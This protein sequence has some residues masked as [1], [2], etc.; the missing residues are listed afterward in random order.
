M[1]LSLAPRVGDVV[2]GYRLLRGLGSR[3][4]HRFVAANTN[5]RRTTPRVIVDLLEESEGRVRTAR[6]LA[7][8]RHPK[9]VPVR[10]VVVEGRV[11]AVESDFVGGEWFADLL[12][13]SGSKATPLGAMLRVLLDVLEGLSALH[14]LG[15]P[16]RQPLHFM[17]G[18]LAPP[19]ILIGADGVARIAHSVRAAA[20]DPS[21]PEVIGYLAPEVLLQDQTTDQRADVY[22]AGVLLWEA[23]T[24]RRLHSAMDAGE[25]VVSLLGGRVALAEVPR[26]APWAQPLAEVAKRALSPELAARHTTAAEMAA[27]VRSIAGENLGSRQDVAG[28]VEALAGARIRAR[29]SGGP[30]WSAKA[31]ARPAPLVR[32]AVPPPAPPRSLPERL[33]VPTPIIP[34]AA[35]AAFARA[36]ASPAP[37]PGP[38]APSEPESSPRLPAPLGALP[39]HALPLPE[40]TDTPII[41]NEPDDSEAPKR[42]R[43]P[44]RALLATAAAAAL[45][46]ILGLGWLVVGSGRTRPAPRQ[47]TASERGAS[48]NLRRCGGP[49]GALAAPVARTPSH[50][51]AVKHRDL[52][53][54]L[55]ATHRNRA[56]PSSGRSPRCRFRVL[57]GRR[58]AAAPQEVE[59]HVLS[60][61]DLRCARTSS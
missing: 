12:Q 52:Q 25:I 56:E 15:G 8:L 6:A 17:H 26:E 35:I 30:A 49:E 41:L 36:S 51:D 59:D 47:A 13:S 21:P 10:D 60:F 46:M 58:S 24:G 33:S 31:S 42:Q 27:A 29:A 9:L 39:P 45:P 38:S 48:E 7:Q 1:G 20:A 44:R 55:G 22:S 11:V 57:R 61:G 34:I 37:E 23:L 2:C 43:R 18:E 40:T 3:A 32:S 54:P 28:L 19:N 53:C 5:P 4:G 14:G 16:S 50:C